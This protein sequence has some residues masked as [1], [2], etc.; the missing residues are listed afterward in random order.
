MAM[1]LLYRNGD[2][3]MPAIR[4]IKATTFEEWPNSGIIWAK[5]MSINTKLYEFHII[6]PI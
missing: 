4:S 6:K 2:I 1:V 3:Q 5:S